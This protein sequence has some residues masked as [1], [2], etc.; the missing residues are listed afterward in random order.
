MIYSVEEANALLPDLRVRI[1]RIR[2]GRK[3]LIE[4]AERIEERIAADG[5]GIAD[6]AWFEVTSGMKTDI[7]AIAGMGVILRDPDEGLIDFP[8]QIEGEQAFLCWRSEE[9]EVAFWHPPD[10]GFAGRRAL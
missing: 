1:E 7:E 3:A 10:S 4:S 9:P 8:T 5:G 6:S 2:Q